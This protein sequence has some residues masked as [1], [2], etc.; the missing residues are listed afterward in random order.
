MQ[1]NNSIIYLIF[2]LIVIKDLCHE[3]I[4]IPLYTGSYANTFSFTG[5]LAPCSAWSLVFRY[6]L[7]DKRWFLIRYIYASFGLYLRMST[8]ERMAVVRCSWRWE[9][10]SRMYRTRLEWIVF[11]WKFAYLVFN[12]RIVSKYE[13]GF[14]C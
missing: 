2:C 11:S 4:C 13:T 12:M 8:S 14:E 10:I 5:P 1:M 9:K 6:Y 3:P 7:K